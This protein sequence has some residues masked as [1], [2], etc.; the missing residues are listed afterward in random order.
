MHNGVDQGGGALHTQEHTH[1]SAHAHLHTHTGEHA[2]QHAGLDPATV[3][4]HEHTHT[5]AHEH[6]CAP[7]T[8]QTH[9]H[10]AED[11][12]NLEEV[13]ALLAYT[14]QHNLHHN[15]ELMQ[16]QEQLRALGLGSAA[17]Q[18]ARS[19]ADFSAGN[20]RLSDLLK[21]LQE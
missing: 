13:V 7:E 21:T 14:L 19:M 4:T 15:A 6:A 1:E 3:H 11:E 2:H 18:L 8:E 10:D 16:M 5:L 17:E 9:R 20:D 12:P